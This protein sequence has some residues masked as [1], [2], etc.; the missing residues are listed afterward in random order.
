MKLSQPLVNPDWRNEFR[1][2]EAGIRNDCFELISW[3]EQI[4]IVVFSYLMP[5]ISTFSLL[6]KR[7]IGDKAD[8]GQ[9]ISE[10][11]DE[12]VCPLALTAP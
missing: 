1:K 8:L 11:R 2:R 6:I 9:M 12:H 10:K 5:Y 7:D 3:S 4:Q